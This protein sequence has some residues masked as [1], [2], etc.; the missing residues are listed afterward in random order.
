VS[1]QHPFERIWQMTPRQVH[2]W[3]QLGAARE[4]RERAIGLGDM[5]LAA[6]G[7]GEAIRKAL[8]ELSGDA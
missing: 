1:W 3:L 6:Q 2:A 7:Q 8:R 4:A 5:A